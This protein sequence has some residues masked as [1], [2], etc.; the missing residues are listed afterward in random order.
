LIHW[1]LSL[2]LHS[3]P[4]RSFKVEMKRLADCFPCKKE[5]VQML[6]PHKFKK[7]RRIITEKE[8]IL[9]KGL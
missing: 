6:L 2:E 3:V 8:G 5:L 7:K 9:T 4:V 1:L